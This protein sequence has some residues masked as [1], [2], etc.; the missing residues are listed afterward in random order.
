MRDLRLKLN[1]VFRNGFFVVLILSIAMVFSYPAEAFEE[2][3]FMREINKE[4]EQPVDATVGMMG[5]I[6]VLDKKLG[7]IFKFNR[8]GKLKF[9]F[10]TKGS[11][12]SQFYKPESIALSLKGEIIVADTGNHRVQVL[13]PNGHFSYEL[14]QFGNLSGQFREPNSVAVDHHGNILVGDASLNTI[15]KFSPNGVFLGK[16]SL[17]SKPTDIAFDRKNNLYV[18]Y[19][20]AGKLMKYSHDLKKKKEIVVGDEIR[21]YLP[22]AQSFT[23]D[24]RGDVYLVE[25]S[26]HRIFKLDQKKNLLFAFGSKGSGKGQFNQPKGIHADNKGHIFVAD[27][28]NSRIQELMISGSEKEVME[29]VQYAPPALDYEKSIFIGK[30]VSDI[31]YIPDQG[32][33]A[34]KEVDGQIVLKGEKT[35]RLKST[36]DDELSLKN[37]KA[38]HITRDGS[39]LVADSGNHRL[40][41]L[42]PDGT[43][44]YHFGKK[45]TDASEFNH[46]EGV[47]HDLR[48]NIYVADTNNHRIQV[49]NSDGIYLRS[50]GEKTDL[51][52]SDV[53][54][55]GTFIQ[56]KDL[57]FNSHQEL[58]ILD[59]RN[60]RIQV[61]D[62]Q[63]KFLD[64]IGLGKNG[65]SFDNPVDIT[66]DD[67]DYLYVADRGSHEVK[68]F[69]SDHKLVM[70]FG[71][72][73][74][75]RS[76][77]PQL[78]S[79]TT[80]EGKIYVADYL[81]DKV[82]VFRYNI[83]DKSEKE[84]L[85]LTRISKPLNMENSS[86]EIQNAMS[87]K[88]LLVDLEKEFIEKIGVAKEDY[89][90]TF[91]I[92]EEIILGNG[93]IQMTISIP[94]S[95]IPKQ[96]TVIGL[97]NQ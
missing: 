30:T 59:H 49:F 29:K 45:G 96:Y 16:W 89:E 70:A 42:G 14:G 25:N 69:N 24:F 79:I 20:E 87:R 15:S 61:L 76:Y 84:F 80:S 51:S 81:V 68:I 10:G 23:I 63:G 17:E 11:L 65:I 13:K 5:S 52:L 27:A 44:Q 74:K 1:T 2:V 43:Y 28:K 9:S 88:L 97:H 62:R 71:S 67:Q 40:Q 41:F 60:K 53:P 32:L 50:F 46:L 57:A 8:K 22:H 18:L 3:K 92:E 90:S 72:T 4:M 7:Q 94:R 64:Q 55:P 34:L 86:E 66:I 78:S 21:K 31:D 47:A 77:F 85:M 48:G 6:Y 33:Y 93:L 54:L 91:K 12:Q 35:K 58:Y 75:G 83:K 56:P 95:I 39:I 38:I 37:P 73:G 82:Q 36:E 26:T 19:T